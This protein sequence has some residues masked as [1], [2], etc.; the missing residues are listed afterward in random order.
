MLIVMQEKKEEIVISPPI[1]QAEAET[2]CD[3]DISDDKNEGLAQH[4]PRRLL[5]APC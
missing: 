4:M 2:D 3:N 1:E 5:T